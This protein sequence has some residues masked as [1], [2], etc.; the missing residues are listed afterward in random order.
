MTTSQE[1]ERVC[2][3]LD[4]AAALIRDLVLERDEA[5]E[6]CA[7]LEEKLAATETERDEL[8]DENRGLRVERRCA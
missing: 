4:D 1:T 3:V 6:R 7:S 2:G 8:A 5:L